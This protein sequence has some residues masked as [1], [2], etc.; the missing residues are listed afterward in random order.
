MTAGDAEHEALRLTRAG[1][2]RGPSLAER[3]AD[4]L[5]RLAFASPV[6]R[7]RLRGRY[8]LKLLAVPADP[9]PGDAAR[10]ARLKGGRLFRDGYGQGVAD[11]RL[12]SPDAPA[13]WRRWV[14]SWGWLRDLA[15]ADPHAQST[16]AEA[17]ARNWLACFPEYDAIA[18][19][20]D[21]TGVRVRRAVQHAPRVMPGLDQVHRSAVLNGIAR[22]TRHL[23]RAAPRLPV[24]LARAEALA[25]LLM[26]ALMLPGDEARQ[27]RAE[28]LLAETLGQLVGPDGE[29]AT[30]CPLDL[31]ELGDLLLELTAAYAARGFRS[32]RSLA[33]AFDRVR[34]G[35]AVLAMGDG[36]PAPWHGGQPDRAALARL[37]VAPAEAAPA[38]ASGF[39]RLAAGGTRVILDA[40][41]PP[42]LRLSDH[43]HAS[44]LAFVMSDGARPLI[45]SCG[46][47]R[48]ADGPRA[49]PPELLMGL[50]STAG[51]S[52]LVL[53]DTNSSRLPDGSPRR[54]GGVEEVAVEARSLP[55]GQL[56]EARHDG[57]RRRLGFDHLRR[58]WL[59]A[60]GDDLRGEDH[61]LP[62][63]SG[64][65]LAR[66]RAP[67]PVA[68]R[69]HL[70]PGAEAALTADGR[71]ALVRLPGSGRA[72]P[73]VA[74][75]FRASFNHGPGVVA[76]EP[77]LMIDS[78]GVAHEIQQ[79][80]LTAL[81]TPG[82]SGDISWS[83][84]RLARAGP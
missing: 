30:R 39:R 3:V 72:D 75:A 59:S 11:A 79:I 10:G 43:G 25:G 78:E 33:L 49:L 76:I 80:L 15:E 24:G 44:T 40:G 55:A 71:G 22:W 14:D 81:V 29:M 20:P 63:R 9:V 1:G 54:L 57:W 52:A 65:A 26:G 48:S 32:P 68:I 45:V 16:V 69:F 83:F 37:G 19:A 4:R 60:E 5:D 36:M 67:L 64:L 41:P 28:A 61:L 73:D 84:R 51:H 7:L 35:L 66:L 38:P 62:V 12:D 18:W 82:E 77:S 46:A 47:G 23:E 58:L 27:A 56:V 8:P 34:Q 74:W 13:A 50:R 53:A 2:D 31:A 70:G 6:H 21:V 17:L 42:P